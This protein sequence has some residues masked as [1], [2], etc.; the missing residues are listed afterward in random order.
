MHTIFVP[1]NWNGAILMDC[2]PIIRPAN[3][4]ISVGWEVEIRVKKDFAGYAKVIDGKN[5]QWQNITEGMSYLLI[6][7]NSIYLKTVL[8]NVFGFSVNNR[9]APNFPV[10]FGFC[11]WTERH[12]PTHTAMFN[13][14]YGKASEKHTK[15][16]HDEHS[17]ADP[18]F[19]D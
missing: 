3:E 14:W 17:Q 4:G 15:V 16:Y 9:P 18:I 13:K 7:N 6:G 10:F 2:F 8:A 19:A 5:I 12:M 11:Q 1:D